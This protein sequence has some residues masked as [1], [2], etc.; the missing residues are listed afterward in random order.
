VLI[1]ISYALASATSAV[2]FT[3]LKPDHGPQFW[4]HH[5]HR[6]LVEP[7]QWF[8][9]GTDWLLAKVL[10][11]ALGIALISYFRGARPK[12]SNRDVSIGITTTILWSTLYVLIVHFA[13]AFVEFKKIT[14]WEWVSSLV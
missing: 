12:Y 2:A 5:Y 8:F 6:E 7:G 13:F 4:A 9:V 11:C 14:L 1:A 10:C 3:I